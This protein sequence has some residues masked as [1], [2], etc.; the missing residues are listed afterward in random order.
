MSKKE[1]KEIIRM[2]EFWAIVVIAILFMIGSVMPE[3]SLL[4][5]PFG[6]VAAGA[7]PGVFAIRFSVPLAVKFVRM[8]KRWNKFRHKNYSYELIATDKENK[9]TI[10]FALLTTAYSFAIIYN[11]LS[12]TGIEETIFKTSRMIPVFA[13]IGVLSLFG[14]ITT[15]VAIF[16]LKKIRF[17]YQDPSDCSKINLGREMETKLGWAISPIILISLIHSISTKSSD[18]F[19]SYGVV[20]GIFIITLYSSFFSFYFLKRVHLEKILERLRKQ[21]ELEMKSN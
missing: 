2:K 19:F 10:K 18:L 14:A 9:S 21:L 20:F 1:F 5:L 17:M 16:L 6:L 8:H 12:W 13:G 15:H 7:I 11:V 3:Y 4:Q